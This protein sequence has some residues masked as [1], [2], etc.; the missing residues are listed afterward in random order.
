MAPAVRVSSRVLLFTAV[1]AFGIHRVAAESGGIEV[2]VFDAS[3]R[4]PV[5]GASVILSSALGMVR[6]TTVATS[7][8]GVAFFPVLRPGGGYVVEVAAPGFARVRVVDVRVRIQEIARVP[9]RLVP[10]IHESVKVVE[11]RAAVDLDKT[12]RATTFDDSFIQDLPS[13]GRF[14]QGR[15]RWPRGSWTRMGTGTRTFT[16]RGRRTSRRRWAG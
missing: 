10:E 14:Y 16:G 4:N 2:R 5:A 9:I 6:T 3:G 13:Q 1:V 11:R 8:K 7:A 15:S 12:S